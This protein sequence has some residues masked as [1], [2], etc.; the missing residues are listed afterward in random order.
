MRGQ[1]LFFFPPRILEQLG[2]PRLLDSKGFA[3]EPLIVPNSVVDEGEVAFLRMITRADVADVP[4][5]GNFFIGLADQLPDD[6]D[7]LPDVT[8]E[9]T[10]TNGYARIA[11]TRDSVGWPNEFVVNGDTG[12]GTATQTF[13]ASG[14]PFSAPFSR[15]FLCNVGAGTAGKLFS[16]SGALTTPVTLLAGETFPMQYEMYM[17]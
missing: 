2:L 13:A 7:T 9:P 6:T 8:S 17:N 3:R 4:A 16:Y 12:I 10:V 11:V 14:G 15:A 1:F 5:A